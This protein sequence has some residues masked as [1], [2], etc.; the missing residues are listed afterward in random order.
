[1]RRRAHG[2]IAKSVARLRGL[3]A[4]GSWAARSS[5]PRIWPQA[6]EDGRRA[7]SSSCAAPIGA[8]PRPSWRSAPTW[9]ERPPCSPS[10]TSTSRTSAPGATAT[11]GWCGASTTS[12]RRREMPYAL[13]LVR[14]AASALLASRPEASRSRGMSAAAICRAILE[15]YRAGLRCAARR[16][17]STATGPGCASCWSSPT[18]SA[19]SSGARSRRPGVQPAPARYRRAL[20]AA[21][22]EPRLTDVDRAP[23]RGHRQPRVGRAGSAWPIGEARRSCARS[24]SCC[25]PAWQPGAPDAAGAGHPLREI[26]G[27]R[28]RAKDPWY[29]VE[30]NMLLRRLSPNN[31]KVEAEKRGR[32]R[33]SRPTCCGAMGHELANVHLGT[34][35][36]RAAILRDLARRKAGWLRPTPSARPPPS[37]ATSRNGRRWRSSCHMSVA[38]TWHDAGEQGCPVRLISRVPRSRGGRSVRTQSARPPCVRCQGQPGRP[39]LRPPRWRAAR[40]APF[41]PSA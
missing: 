40:L 14:L 30:G 18:S 2:G 21:M 6:R 1:M 41:C 12:T 17:C 36:R 34:G 22:P 24:R 33:C 31:R 23:H 15:G 28:F 5:R 11:A 9:R 32:R 19:Q 13:D 16:S 20:A 37:P 25:P 3:A 4:T 10:A 38:C 8:G 39:L 29:R 7:R 27:G 35:D 26:A